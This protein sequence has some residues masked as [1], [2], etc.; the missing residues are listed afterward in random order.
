[1]YIHLFECTVGC[2]LLVTC[3]Y[4]FAA[5]ALSY[6]ERKRNVF[7]QAVF[8]I[9]ATFVMWHFVLRSVYVEQQSRLTEGDLVPEEATLLGYPRVEIGYTSLVMSFSGDT[10][11]NPSPIPNF[12][13][14][15][16]FTAREDSNGIVLTTSVKD[17]NGNLI[18]DL[19]DNHWRVYPSYS[20]DKNYTRNSLE[21]KDSSGEVVLQVVLV[22]V[23][24]S[25]T[26]HMAG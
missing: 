15:S 9:C 17:R 5:L 10:P 14:R 16:G 19:K 6:S 1:M 12:A 4:L 23:N 7:G 25:P 8:A 26:R 3:I 20:T 11:G 18:M 22:R 24:R 13:Y 21:V 2:P